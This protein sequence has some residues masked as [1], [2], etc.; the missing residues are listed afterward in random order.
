MSEDRLRAAVLTEHDAMS[1][2]HGESC[3]C[4][5]CLALQRLADAALAT[6]PDPA[7]D[8]PEDRAALWEK[9]TGG[10]KLAYGCGYRDAIRAQGGLDVERLARLA[11]E[12]RP[13]IGKRPVPWT[14]VLRREW[15][16]WARRILARP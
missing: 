2:R 11:Y 6:P 1:E 10:E 3:D 15:T 8:V 12:D 16:A 4:E 13:P 9:F 14:P 5:V 7:P